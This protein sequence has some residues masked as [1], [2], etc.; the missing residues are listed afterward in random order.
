MSSSPPCAA[1]QAATSAGWWMYGRSPPL[2]AWPA[3][4]CSASRRA[5]STMPTQRSVCGHATDVPR[6][7]PHGDVLREQL[8]GG[9]HPRVEGPGRPA[10]VLVCL[11]GRRVLLLR[12]AKDER[13][14]WSGH[15]SLPGGRHEPADRG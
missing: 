3:W 15:V 6:A 5:S 10:A 13:D 9:P 7:V 11:H 4:A 8:A 14:P 1:T 12:R 2:R